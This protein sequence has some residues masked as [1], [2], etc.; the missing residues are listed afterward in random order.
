MALESFDKLVCGILDCA[1]DV[2]GFDVTYMPVAGGSF[3]IR[4]IFDN[5]F[6]QVD[7]D[8]ETVIAS[9]IPRL[10]LKLKDLKDVGVVPCKKDR[11]DVKG[12]LYQ[13]VD[14]QED[15]QGASELWLHKVC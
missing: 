6:Q 14:S 3:T 7:P 9:N 13:V 10:N 15:G 12:T 2:F 1:V 8:T 5:N 11:V 4:A